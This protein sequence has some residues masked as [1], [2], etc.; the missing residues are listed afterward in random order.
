MEDEAPRARV[1][2][3]LGEYPS[4]TAAL[5][6]DCGSLDSWWHGLQKHPVYGG[7]LR[8]R[9]YVKKPGCGQP[10]DNDLPW[11]PHVHDLAIAR[12]V[13]ELWRALDGRHPRCT[14]EKARFNLRAPYASDDKL[15][16]KLKPM[17]FQELC[18]F[19]EE[20]LLPTQFKPTRKRKADSL[21]PPP[22]AP[23]VDEESEDDFGTDDEMVSSEDRR[24]YH[25]AR[26]SPV[27]ARETS[28]RAKESS[29]PAT[30]IAEEQSRD[31]T[32]DLVDLLN[33]ADR[34]PAAQAEAVGLRDSLIA[35]FMAEVVSL[36]PFEVAF[37]AGKLKAG[38]YAHAAA[39]M[40]RKL[41][42]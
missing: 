2:D 21:A 10:S 17:D 38:L 36:Q 5:Q 31:A 4:L 25:R 8:A 39:F 22:P 24:R 18:A 14:M 37:L 1:G 6:A 29:V 41:R 30:E 40:S 11:Y 12:D 23:A 35:E 3:C 9:I 15:V 19:I 42:V 20:L 13:A 33:E 26:G 34:L 32:L 28:V 27:T 16:A 7:Y